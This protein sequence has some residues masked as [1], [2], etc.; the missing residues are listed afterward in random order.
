MRKT[1]TL[2]FATLTLITLAAC[3]SGTNAQVQSA[4]S[5]TSMASSGAGMN[6]LTDADAGAVA[7]T[8][9]DGEIQTSQ[10]ALTNATS[11]QVRDFAQ[12][13]IDDHT[14]ANKQLQANGYVMHENPVTMVLNA[15]V[16]RRL[17]D[18]R[19]RS[20]SDFDRHYIAHQ[21]DLHQT[22]L[23]TLRTTLQP[24]AREENLRQTLNVMRQS[25]EMHLEQARAIQAQ[26]GGR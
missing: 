10:V 18:L 16:N 23:E 15:D 19:G 20:G 8:I 9:N 2:L 22:A 17:G 24:S 7:R 13:M 6:Q 3:R 26:I 1:T 4:V 21:I 12:M 11:Q 25:V 5:Q 14:N